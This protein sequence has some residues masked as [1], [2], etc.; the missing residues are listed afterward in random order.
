MTDMF[1]TACP[2]CL[3]AA[4]DRLHAGYRSGCK[5]CAARAVAR[6]PDFHRCRTAGKQDRRYRDLLTAVG[7]THE[8]VVKA[9]EARKVPA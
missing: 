7:V 1:A 4:A 2:D 9:Y 5:G 8:A 3:A 6:G